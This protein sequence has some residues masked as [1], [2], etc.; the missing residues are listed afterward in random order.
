MAEFNSCASLLNQEKIEIAKKEYENMKNSHKDP[1][2]IMLAMQKS[3]QEALFVKNPKVQDVNNLN[4]LGEKYDWIR[5]NKIAFDD[6]FRETV[7]AL[8]GMNKSEKDRSA[9]WKKWKKNYDILRS[10]DYDKLSENEKIE[11]KFEVCDMFHFFMNIMLAVNLNAEE[12]FVYYM[13]KNKENFDRIKR[14]Y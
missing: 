5:D 8:A 2:E 11:L 4:T 7:D 1:F 10:E 3:L 14:G 9:L 6:E 13:Y 12:M